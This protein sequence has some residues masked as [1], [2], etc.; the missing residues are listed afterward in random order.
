MKKKL[1]IL[2][3]LLLFCLLLPSSKV[4]ANSN[5]EV[6]KKQYYNQLLK[7]GYSDYNIKFFEAKD[8]YDIVENNI[9]LI[10]S[11]TI[12]NLF[13]TYRV[14]DN[15]MKSKYGDEIYVSTTLNSK[16]FNEYS[17]DK[18]KYLKKNFD[19]LEK[20]FD[21]KSKKDIKIKNKEKELETDEIFDD[22][23]AMI[24]PGDDSYQSTSKTTYMDSGV[25]VTTLSVSD[26][27]SYDT[28]YKLLA[29]DFEW[30]TDPMFYWDDAIGIAHNGAY[31][32]LTDIKE[33]RFY[34]KN[35]F[36]TA[37]EDPEYTN[38][39]VKVNF[40]PRDRNAIGRLSAK[41][42][43][44]KSAVTEDAYFIAYA[45]MGHVSIGVRTNDVT[46]SR[47]GVDISV[48]IGGVTKTTE[49]HKLNGIF[50]H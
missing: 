7:L 13:L 24:E 29:F 47:S 5:D 18:K 15:K 44:L 35:A 49:Q 37:Y 1:R 33:E 50:T 8:V 42:G 3:S 34:V 20:V 2:F 46:L 17:K 40:P 41:V 43:N 19:K 6:V 14:N 23:I 39:G 16:E 11:Q 9:T 48:G 36:I 4:F 10:E 12:N 22:L 26:A 38:E 31:L 25:L 21:K 27:S 28:C 32:G 45:R 30:T